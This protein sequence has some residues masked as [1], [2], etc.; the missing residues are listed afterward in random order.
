L[1]ALVE[2]HRAACLRLA[3]AA[4]CPLLGID[5]APNADGVWRMISA[6]VIPDLTRGGEVLIDALARALT[7]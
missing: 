6:S 7:P 3:N 4:G 5:F 2:P 1:D